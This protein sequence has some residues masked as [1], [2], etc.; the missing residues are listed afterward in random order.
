MQGLEGHVLVRWHDR[1]GE[2]AFYFE[3]RNVDPALAQDAL[4]RM[5]EGSE[6]YVHITGTNWQKLAEQ[7]APYLK[8][9]EGHVRA[10][11]V[12]DGQVYRRGYTYFVNATI[13][14]RDGLHLR[15]AA[16]IVRKAG[17]YDKATTIEIARPDK[18][19]HVNAK[20]IMGVLTL[21][22]EKGTKLVTSAKGPDAE[23]AVKGLY[24]TIQGIR[25]LE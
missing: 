3:V 22:A 14:N 25:N 16:E 23:Q 24:A 13:I 11:E 7:L 15:A 19:I 10:E 12:S 18:N 5:T 2:N 1:S 17:S 21:V 6:L 20:S 9:V 8:P 4:R